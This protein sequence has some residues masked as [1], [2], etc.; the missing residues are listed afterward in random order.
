MTFSLDSATALLERAPATLAVL[1][2]QLPDGW[3]RTNEGRD[4][5]SPF[6]VVGHL[7]HGEKTDWIVRARIIREHGEAR[8]FDR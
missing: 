8:P 2:G 5:F 1:L 4:T 3:T 7:I 6:D